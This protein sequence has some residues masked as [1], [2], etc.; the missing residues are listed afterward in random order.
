[1]DEH[2]AAAALVAVQRQVVAGDWLLSRHAR[3]EL[4]AELITP[5]EVREAIA[6][7]AILEPIPFR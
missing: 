7:G 4:D 6:A 2:D 5:A 1:M 3:Q